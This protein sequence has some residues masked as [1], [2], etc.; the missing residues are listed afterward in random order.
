MRPLKRSPVN[1]HSSAGHFKAQVGYTK[2]ANV[3]A[4]PMRGGWRL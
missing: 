4:T 3:M 2:A 1:K